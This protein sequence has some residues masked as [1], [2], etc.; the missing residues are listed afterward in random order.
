[1]FARLQ[2]S[3]SLVVCSCLLLLGCSASAEKTTSTK[4]VLWKIEGQNVAPSWLLATVQT[5]AGQ[6]VE[7]KPEVEPALLSSKYIGTEYFSDMNSS[8]QLA[9]AMVTKEAT[10]EKQLGAERYAK[11]SPLLAARGYPANV[12]AK[13]Q[14]WAAAMLLFSPQQGKENVPMDEYIFQ[15]ATETNKPYFALETIEQQLSPFQGL[16]IARQLVLIDGFIA[17]QAA[18]EDAYKKNM[19]AYIQSDLDKID[20]YAQFESIA[21]PK[22]EQAWFKQWRQK[23]KSQRNQILVERLKTPLGKGEAFFTISSAQVVGNDGLLV[24]LRAAGYKVTPV[25]AEAKP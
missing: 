4:A 7:F 3:V 1:M 25:E 11:L 18:L 15:Y 6:D 20:P 22:T 9:Q 5:P 10:L 8:I 23:L 14:P 2:S 13:L 24:A 17:H 19:A 21:L 16:P 12:S